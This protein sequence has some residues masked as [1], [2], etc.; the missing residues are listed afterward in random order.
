MPIPWTH[1][2]FP[3]HPIP[4]PPCIP[5]RSLAYGG[6]AYTGILDLA[7]NGDDVHFFG[8]QVSPYE[9]TLVVEVDRVWYG[10]GSGNDMGGT[11]AA[12]DVPEGSSVV[13]LRVQG[14]P[15]RKVVI[16]R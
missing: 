2:S 11:G 1:T 9:T 12:P 3:V 6:K 7:N 4:C 13:F 16:F 5:G 15:D 14:A 10:T 8:G